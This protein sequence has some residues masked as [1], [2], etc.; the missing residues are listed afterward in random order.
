MSVI[1]ILHSLTYISSLT[2]TPFTLTR[3]R[4][5]FL[6]NHRHPFV[7]HTLHNL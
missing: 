4:G 7:F 1:G 3:T 2:V 6:F 5:H